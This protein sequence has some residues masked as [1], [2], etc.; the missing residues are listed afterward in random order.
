MPKQT[1]AL[2]V[3][4]TPEFAVAKDDIKKLQEAAV[5]Q[6][7]AVAK[8]E[9][10]A[11]KG[12]VLAGLTLHRVKASLPYGQFG[13]WV[14]KI[15]T[16]GGK[17]TVKKSQ[18]NN[19]MRL[20]SV[21]LERC[22]VQKP[23]LLAL[24]GD[25]TALDLGDGAEA[26]TLFSKLHKFVGECSLNELL[27]KYGIKG[28]VREG[29]PGTEEE[30][31]APAAGAAEDYFAEVAESVMGFRSIVTSRDALVRLSP[32]QLDTLHESVTDAYSQFKQLYQEARGKKARS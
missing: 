16:S 31:A 32:Q 10:N 26:R 21:F 24:P 14:E 28:V 2:T 5:E 15:S 8:M 22:K 17:V 6:C 11:A 19:Y 30:T 20:S 12:A 23:D 4:A 25:Q 1:H 3:L 27:V 18:A 29:D 13:K 9:S 7:S